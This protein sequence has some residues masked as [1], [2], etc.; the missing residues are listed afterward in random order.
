MYYEHS[1]MSAAV[2]VLYLESLLSLSD[3]LADGISLASLTSREQLTTI[4]ETGQEILKDVAAGDAPTLV[5][6]FKVPI[7]G[8][9]SSE[10]LQNH[11]E[12]LDR[13]IV[14]QLEAR[15][16]M[17]LALMY[18]VLIHTK[19]YAALISKRGELVGSAGRKCDRENLQTRLQLCQRLGTIRYF[20]IAA[21]S[22]GSYPGH[23]GQELQEQFQNAYSMLG[24]A[25]EIA[26]GYTRY[27]Q[28]LATFNLGRLEFI[29]VAKSQN[30][31]RSY[32][33]QAHGLQA[34]INNRSFQALT[35]HYLSA[36]EDQQRYGKVI[37]DPLEYHGVLQ[38]LASLKSPLSRIIAV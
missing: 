3:T 35:T 8:Q 15:L 33:E 37:D 29:D 10:K 36:L 34:S 1:R 26:R 16:E 6:A 30:Q 14:P 20:D 13:S 4:A 21:I 28:F 11:S 31:A 9:S 27:D 25:Q 24:I 12:E 7:I 22:L 18:T 2:K 32:L 23:V 19:G 38:E 5:A 17:N